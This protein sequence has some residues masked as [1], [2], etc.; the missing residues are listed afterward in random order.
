MALNSGVAAVHRAQSE[1]QMPRE[2]E[3]RSKAGKLEDSHALKELRKAKADPRNQR[4]RPFAAVAQ[5]LGL[6]KKTAARR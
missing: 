1:I 6:L 5:E 2:I 3:I 4:G